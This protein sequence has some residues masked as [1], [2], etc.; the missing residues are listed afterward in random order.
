MNNGGDVLARGGTKAQFRASDKVDQEKWDQIFP[1]AAEGFEERMRRKAI[2]EGLTEEQYEQQKK[3]ALHILEQKIL[4]EQQTLRER[5][6][7]VR[8]RAV[9]DRIIVRRVE[10][11]EK[12]GSLYRPDEAKEKPYEGDVVAVGPGRYLATGE[13]I[14]VS[15]KLGERVVFGR[16]SGAETKHGYE[17]LLVLREED[18]FYVKETITDKTDKTGE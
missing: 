8:I 14:P 18:I 1:D 7:N 16:F 4:E 9:Q 10:V 2:A 5:D 11:E 17:D 13:F 3:E 15:I 12:V 6:K